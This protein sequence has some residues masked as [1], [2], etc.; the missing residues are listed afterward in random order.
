MIQPSS[1]QLA[2]AKHLL[3]QALEQFASSPQVALQTLQQALKLCRD[4]DLRL[5]A[6]NQSR[7][8]EGYILCTLGGCYLTL[9]QA[10]TAL[11]SYQQALSLFKEVGNRSAKEVALS[12]LGFIYQELGQSAQALSYYQQALEVARAIGERRQEGKPLHSVGEVLSQLG[13]YLQG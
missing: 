3:Q 11:E 13:Q 12:N 9:G 8:Q 4:K 5:A 6:F 10:S 7:E 1:N 2:E